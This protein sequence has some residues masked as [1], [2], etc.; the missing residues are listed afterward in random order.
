MFG[1]I[2]NNIGRNH[3]IFLLDTATKDSHTGF[4]IRHLYLDGQTRI[5]TGDETI[6]NIF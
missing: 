5:E 3:K 6:A 4:H 2:A 1:N